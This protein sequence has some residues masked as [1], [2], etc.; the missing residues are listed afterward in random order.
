MPGRAWLIVVTATLAMACALAWGV[1]YGDLTA[2]GGALLRMPWGLVSLVEIYIGL[3][4][5]GCWVFWREASAA[6]ASAWMLAA[7]LIGNIVSCIYVLLAM[8]AARGDVSKFW[9]GARAP[10]LGRG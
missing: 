3:T 10:L 7:V 2:E 6:R 9:L 4:L 8:R 1:L 5:F